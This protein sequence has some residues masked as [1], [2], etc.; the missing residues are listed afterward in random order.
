MLK[1]Q[2]VKSRQR[3]FKKTHEIK[4]Q[5]R[6]CKIPWT[7][8]YPESRGD[9]RR[10]LLWS[11]RWVRSNTGLFACTNQWT[12]WISK[13]GLSYTSKILW[14]FTTMKWRQNPADLEAYP[15]FGSWCNLIE[16]FE[17]GIWNNYPP[18]GTLN[19]EGSLGGGATGK[20]K[21]NIL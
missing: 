19:G 15:S 11:E 8:E 20:E 17:V 9:N 10:Q 16:S 14:S 18:N 3:D 13:Q 5:G 1:S 21:I 6:G 2:H 12:P 7:T 4:D